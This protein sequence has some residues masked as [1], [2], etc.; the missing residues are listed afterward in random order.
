[1]GTHIERMLTQTMPAIEKLDNKEL[2]AINKQDEFIDYLYAEIN[3]Y[4]V[5]L[6]KQEL[7]SDQ[8]EELL[9]LMQIVSDFESI[10]DLL[11]RD[12]VD[13]GKKCINEQLEL[14]GE[15]QNS[16]EK[17]FNAV[18]ET[19]TLVLI[20]VNDP[21]VVILEEVKKKKTYLKRL[22]NKLNND[23]LDVA[24][25]NFEELKNYSLCSDL[26]DTYTRIFYHNQ[27]IAKNLQTQEIT[28]D[29]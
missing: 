24:R 14:S 4:L 11:E 3:S 22:T 23:K 10:G 20:S 9:T 6:S 8:S 1:M 16:L 28:D 25:E 19:F 5:K 26:V 15:L 18:K 29:K 17:T 7:T 21:N 2:N 12:I 13:I 27:K